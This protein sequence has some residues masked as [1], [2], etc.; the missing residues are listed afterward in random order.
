MLILTRS[1]RLVHRIL[2]KPP[3]WWGSLLGSLA[4]SGCYDSE[5][6]IPL[7]FSFDPECEES[8]QLTVSGESL[9]QGG[10]GSGRLDPEATL[11]SSQWGNIEPLGEKEFFDELGLNKESAQDRGD[12]DELFGSEELTFVFYPKDDSE[13]EFEGEYSL[14]LYRVPRGMLPT[15][16]SPSVIAI[17]D[18]SA[19]G[20]ARPADD[21]TAVAAA[22][23]ELAEKVRDTDSAVAIMAYCPSSDSILPCRFR[24]D[25]IYASGGEVELSGL[26]RE[27]GLFVSDDEDGFFYPR[28]WIDATFQA[29]FPSDQVV[30]S[31][32]TCA[33]L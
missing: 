8:F 22:F 7:D 1:T 9:G 24:S 31:S 19:I 12:F 3:L 28:Y 20:E 26:I 30:E 10:S 2:S 15:S 21:L 33:K 5:A 32:I 6:G 13:R 17:Q 29:T 23:R 16:Q 25:A 14:S 18:A 27:D 11:L 4:T